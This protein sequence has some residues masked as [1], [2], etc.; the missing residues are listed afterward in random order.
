M[1]KFKEKLIHHV[2]TII[3]FKDKCIFKDVLTYTCIVILSNKNT[4]EYKY[5]EYTLDNHKYIKKNTHDK[6]E[7][8][9]Q[10]QQTIKP[11]VG[12][13]TLCDKV[14]IIKEYKI[15]DDYVVFTNKTKTE[16]KQWKIEKDACKDILKVSKNEK[17]KIIYPYIEENS[18][19]NPIPHLEKRYP[20][21][22]SYLLEHKNRLLARDAG[23]A[24]RYPY[25]YCYGRTQALQ[26]CS[27]PRLFIST[28]VNDNL[29]RYMYIDTCDLYYSG[30]CIYED[31]DN[32]MNKILKNKETVLGNSGH[33]HNG[34]YSISHSS[35]KDVF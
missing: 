2:E 11:K 8:Q 31:I 5:C 10:K 23:K 18:K 16:T 32:S 25:W 34:W 13:M 33:K 4:K 17:Y 21:T 12:V 27:K 24:N 35:F 3:D 6:L 15:D 7:L 29:G 9:Q 28:I 19:L 26:C 1:I 20:L 22:Y 30:M 14:F